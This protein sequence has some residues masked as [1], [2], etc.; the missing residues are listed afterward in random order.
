MM[1]QKN[2]VKFILHNLELASTLVA[3]T[4]VKHLKTAE[5]AID[6]Y[7]MKQKNLIRNEEFNMMFIAKFSNKL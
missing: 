7:L 4:A 1:N 3:G 2:A 6:K 5:K